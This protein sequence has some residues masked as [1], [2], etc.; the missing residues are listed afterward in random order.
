MIELKIIFLSVFSGIVTATLLY[1]LSLIIKNII[2]PWYQR[3]IYKGID[4]SGNWKGDYHLSDATCFTSN[5][6]IKQNAHNLSGNYSVT[7]IVNGNQEKV[8]NMRI[9]GE[10]WEGFVSLK[11]RTIS[12]KNLS[13]GSMLLK[14]ND[15]ALNGTYIFRNLA[16]NASAI[17]SFELNLVRD[18][19]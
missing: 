7:R 13:F 1:L 10:V 14:V 16:K 3:I 12:S 15:S 5:L 8:T 11:C 18:E 17:A 19:K 9:S 4:V 6:T 2:I